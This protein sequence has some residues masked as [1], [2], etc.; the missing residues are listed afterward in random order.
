MGR[1]IKPAYLGYVPFG[2]VPG[3]RN[4]AQVNQFPDICTPARSGNDDVV[5]STPNPAQGTITGMQ[6]AFHQLKSKKSRKI[7]WPFQV[8]SS[9]GLVWPPLSEIS[10]VW[11]HT[12]LHLAQLA[13]INTVPLLLTLIT[14]YLLYA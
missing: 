8:G 9:R 5:G 13:R 4:K 14:Y 7:L 10:P 6:T 1:E 3:T 11:A 2:E 12:V